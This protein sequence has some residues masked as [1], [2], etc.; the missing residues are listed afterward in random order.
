MTFV[1]AMGRQK[2]LTPLGVIGHFLCRLLEAKIPL[3]WAKHI[4]GLSVIWCL[5]H[6]LQVAGTK[7]FGISESRERQELPLL[8]PVS[9]LHLQAQ[10]LQSLAKK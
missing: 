2:P 8:G 3:V 7:C 1:Q 6:N 10:S 9:G 4:R 5:L